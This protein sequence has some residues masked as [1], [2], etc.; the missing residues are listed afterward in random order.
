MKNFKLSFCA[1]TLMAVTSTQAMAESVE[2]AVKGTIIPAACTP[3]ITGEINYG[4]VTAE[5]LS[6]TAYTVLDKKEVDFAI[7]CDAPVKVA[8]R[9]INGQPGTV[10]GGG[11]ILANTSQQSPVN[12]LGMATPTVVGLGVDGEAPIGGYA[13][14]LVTAGM[15]ADTVAAE[16][17]YS[18]DAGSNW[19]ASVNTI[20]NLYRATTAGTALLYSWNKA[21]GLAPAAI[22]DYSAKLA[23]QAFLNKKPELDTNK[24]IQL[25]GLT[26]IEL[27]YL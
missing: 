17:L 11:P 3:S 15:I 13:V 23:V 20:S 19:S 14:G 9:T 25:N 22:K 24:A 12:L 4:N 16:P 26:T 8:I 1:V 7:N 10:A 5:Q 18:V 21:D 2:L 6:A 27:V